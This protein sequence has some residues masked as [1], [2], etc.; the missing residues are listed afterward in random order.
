LSEPSLIAIVD[1]DAAMR[2]ALYDLLQVE[3]FRA[4]TFPDA[5]AFL[6]HFDDREIACLI[7]DV[8]MPGLD[9]VDLQQQLRALGHM[10]PVIFVTSDEDEATRAR[11]M[12]SGATAF[13]TKP[14][15]N[16]ELVRVLRDVLGSERGD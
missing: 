5:E 7:T 3:G 14:L 4:V 12:R 9:G 8:R 1:D 16:A 10:L 15:A 11:A 13:F 2:E 6:D